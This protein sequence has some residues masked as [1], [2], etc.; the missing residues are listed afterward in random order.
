MASRIGGGAW[1][2]VDWFLRIIVVTLGMVFSLE[3]QIINQ[4]FSEDLPHPSRFALKN[5]NP[6]DPDKDW[7]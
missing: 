3:C 2:G 6:T 1:Y 7:W 5:E 4:N